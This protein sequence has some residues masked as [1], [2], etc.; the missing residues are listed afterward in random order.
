MNGAP[1][2]FHME[3][4]SIKEPILADPVTIIGV[5]AGDFQDLAQ[6]G[7][8]IIKEQIDY[9]Q[10]RRKP[11]SK[12]VWDA[13]PQ[14]VK[15]P[16]LSTQLAALE[17]KYNL[18]AEGSNPITRFFTRLF[19]PTI[20]FGE[21]V[22]LRRARMA[23]LNAT[24]DSF[25]KLE[26]FQVL[27]TKS[28]KESIIEAKKKL[29]QAWNSW[30]LV[31][32]AFNTY[33]NSKASKMDNKGGPISLDP[34]K[35]N[36]TPFAETSPQEK[37]EK[38]TENSKN[39]INSLIIDF[40]DNLAKLPPEVLDKNISDLSLE[41]EKFLLF[42]KIDPQIITLYEAALQSANNKLSLNVTSFEDL[43]DKIN[44]P[45]QVKAQ[46][47][48]KKWLGKK[49]HQ[50]NPF[51]PVSSIRLECYEL[52]DKI[53]PELNEIMD[54]IEDGLDEDALEPLMRSVHSQFNVLNNL[55]MSLWQTE[56]K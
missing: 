29:E 41:V 3:K 6:E 44:N 16:D 56:A 31:Y 18:V 5:L 33:K 12:E 13:A 4:G 20:G 24:T 47:F 8:D 53:R 27:V 26:K 52:A 39:K 2:K 55:T 11:I 35:D 9:A 50:L 54:L 49:N 37:I 36:P 10:N 30:M 22:H 40:K 28:S 14:T 32:R 42:K 34:K 46:D 21:A 48:L 17:T 15:T 7:N 45:I 1:S 38:L 23:M 19:N 51:S 25:Y 43:V